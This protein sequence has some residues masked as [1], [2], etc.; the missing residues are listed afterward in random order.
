MA[1]DIQQFD[2]HELF[3]NEKLVRINSDGSYI[4]KVELTSAETE[5]LQKHIKQV[6]ERI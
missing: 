1:V 4:A 6:S 3:V 2:D 5:A